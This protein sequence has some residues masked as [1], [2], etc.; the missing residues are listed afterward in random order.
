[1]T[2]PSFAAPTTPPTPCQ[3]VGTDGNAYALL[4]TAGRCLKRAGRRDEY[5][6]M[7]TR[8]FAAQSYQETIA[9]LLEYVTGETDDDDDDD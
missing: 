9:I 8:V 4:A 2:T 3:L 5:D 7:S 1:M 6:A